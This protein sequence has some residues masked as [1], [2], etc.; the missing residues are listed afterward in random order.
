LADEIILPFDRDAAAAEEPPEEEDIGIRR[1]LILPNITP[2]RRR[3]IE[4]I[5]NY[6]GS[7]IVTLA[8]HITAVEELARQREVATAERLRNQEVIQEK[9]AK[10][11]RN[12]ATKTAEK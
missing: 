4:A 3:K 9:R 1:F 6:S 10:R 12:K 11:T 2:I 8:S 7:L 5:V